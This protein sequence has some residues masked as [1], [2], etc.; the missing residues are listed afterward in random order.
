MLDSVT[1]PLPFKVPLVSALIHD[2][3]FKGMKEH[4]SLLTPFILKALEN[5]PLALPHIITSVPLHPKRLRERGYN[6]SELI[7]QAIVATLNTPYPIVIYQE[8]LSRARFTQPQSKQPDRKARLTAL[9]NAFVLKD[10]SLPLNHQII[11]LIDDVTTT[12]ATLEACAQVLKQAGAKEVHGIV[13]A[14]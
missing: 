12:G 6:Q 8:L 14:R 1:A 11:W 13:I 7:A 2:W 10:P 3:K 9:V 5:T 4:T